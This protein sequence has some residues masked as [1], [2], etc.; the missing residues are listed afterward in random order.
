MTLTWILLATLVSGTGSVGLAGAALLLP[1][2]VRRRLASPAISYATGTLLGAALLGL[3]P[4]ALDGLPAAEASGTLLAGLIVFFLLEKMALW[5][6]C[7]AE[8]CTVHPA[9]GW[10]ILVGDSLHNFMDGVAIAAAF[11]TSVPLGLAT[12]AAVAA[13][14]LPQEIGDFFILLESGF[15]RRRAFACNLAS[16]LAAVAGAI[17]AYAGIRE[18]RPAVP[19]A[20]AFSAAGF[21]Y[22]VLADLVPGHR[23]DASLLGG[24]LQL[25]LIG[26]GIATILVL[27]GVG[28]G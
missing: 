3:L 18:I 6:H 13:H 28:A 15:T 16:G 7:H 22:I 1:E 9:T 8:A 26:T 20:M 23:R 24:V 4:R 25:V 19:Y 12:T 27:Q 2:Q 10:L 21:L 5:R 14:E 11:A 17:L